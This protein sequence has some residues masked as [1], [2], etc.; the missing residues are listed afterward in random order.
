M[1]KTIL[2]QTTTIV[3]IFLTALLLNRTSQAEPRDAGTSIPL[4]ET[5]EIL[6]DGYFSLGL[7]PQLRLSDGGG[8]NITAYVDSSLTSD[9]NLRFTIGGGKVDFTTSASIKWVPFPD[10]GRQPAIGFRGALIYAREESVNFYNVQ[11]SPIISKLADTTY[12]KMIPYIGL[13]ITFVSTKDD[14][15]TATQFAVGAEWF[16]NKEMHFGGEFDLNLSHSFT[17]INVFVSFPFD[18]AVGYK[19]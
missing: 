5:A 18:Q 13:P 3:F 16:S 17:A 10:V 4:N 2:K 12:G 9:T 6:P 11:I 19:K 8:F 14:S 15:T 1:K 7:A